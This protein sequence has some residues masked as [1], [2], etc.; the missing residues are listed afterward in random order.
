MVSFAIDKRLGDAR[1]I[2][3]LADAGFDAVDLSLEDTSGGS[4]FLHS[5]GYRD[6]A[7]MLKKAAERSGI[8]FNQA[9]AP[10]R[11][12]WT[13]AGAV[14]NA[15]IPGIARSFEVAS[16]LGIKTVVVHPLNH[17]YQGE[18]GENR[19]EVFRANVDYCR[20]L[21]PH[22]EK[23][24]VV[25]A[26]ENIYLQNALTGAYTGDILANTDDFVR[27][28]DLLPDNRVAACLDVGHCLVTGVEPA[29]AIRRLGRE[30]LAAL[31]IHDNDGVRDR[32]WP[33]FFGVADWE[34]T[35]GAL[36]E[37]GYRG[38]CTLEAYPY[39]NRFPDDFLPEAAR[40]LAAIGRRLLAY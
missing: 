21:V 18:S 27:L 22:A 25:V 32:H 8:V 10:F 38:D 12:D 33:P 29:G 34:K 5:P 26:L 1:A 20:R 6:H 35:M 15:A 23:W 28:L 11:F 13:A 9:H 3:L 7:A 4:W 37:I 40:H 39:W 2:E 16:L 30:R 17:L 31:H 14:E 24:D 19:E 36:R